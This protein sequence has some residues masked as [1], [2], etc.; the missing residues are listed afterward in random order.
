MEYRHYKLKKGKKEQWLNW[1]KYLVENTEEVFDTMK[2][3]GCKRE[4]CW[5]LGEDVFYGMDSLFLGMDKRQLNIEHMKNFKEC[6]QFL[7]KY[8]DPIPMDAVTLFDF[9]L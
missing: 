4:A 7:E 3:E 8:T 5:I 1:A 6:L 9:K 2:E